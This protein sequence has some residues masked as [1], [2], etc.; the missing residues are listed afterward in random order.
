MSMI[1]LTIFSSMW[2]E[3]GILKSGRKEI[4]HAEEILALLDSVMMPKEVAIVPCQSHQNIDSDLA[5]GNNLA[6]QATKPEA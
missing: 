3:N 5:K 6:D 2:T 1:L 4:E